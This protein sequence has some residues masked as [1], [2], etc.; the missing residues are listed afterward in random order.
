LFSLLLPWI[1]FS[2]LHDVMPPSLLNALS[3]ALGVLVE[4]IDLIPLRIISWLLQ[5]MVSL[6][7]YML[8]IAMPHLHPLAISAVAV[9]AFASLLNLIAGLVAFLAARRRA[10]RIAGGCQLLV[11][12]VSLGLLLAAMPCLDQWGTTGDFKAGVQAV[13]LGAGLEFGAWV[14]AAALVLMAAGAVLTLLEPARRPVTIDYG[15]RRKHSGR[16]RSSL[17]R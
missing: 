6:P 16:R 15:Y 8:F 2:L 17:W 7:G 14:A 3:T 5:R 11:S 13:S 10:G 1:R 4:L 9:T 12:V